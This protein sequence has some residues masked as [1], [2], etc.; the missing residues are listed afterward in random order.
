MGA[1]GFVGLGAMGTPMVRRLLA[2]GHDVTGYNR[3]RA[4]AD[5][6][7]SA[8]LRVAGSPR[9]AAAAGPTASW[10]DSG[11]ARSGPT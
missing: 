2:G 8:G 6:L 5:A 3:T 1:V 7:V 4:K 9:E 11:G 10:P